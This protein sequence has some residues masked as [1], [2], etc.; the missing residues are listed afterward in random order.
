MLARRLKNIGE[1]YEIREEFSV[2]RLCPACQKDRLKNA[3]LYNFC[4][5]CEY[6]EMI[7]GI[8][9]DSNRWH[10]YGVWIKMNKGAAIGFGIAIIAVILIAYYTNIFELAKPGVDKTISSTKDAVSQVQGKDVVA[11]SEKVTSDIKNE[12]AKIKIKNPPSLP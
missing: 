12:T 3:G 11:G 6:E 2:K 9:N 10:N 4:E 1:L 5:T 8:S 7:L